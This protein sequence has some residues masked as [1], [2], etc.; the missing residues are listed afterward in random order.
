[1]TLLPKKSELIL[2]IQRSVDA[3]GSI[4]S[5]V[6]NKVLNVSIIES[7][8]NT[9]RSNHYHVKDYHFMYVLEGEIDYFFK[10]LHSDEVNYLKILK[11]ETIF[12]PN[13]EIHATYFAQKTKLIVSSGLPR[14]QKTYENDTRRVEFLNDK[15][16]DIF[17]K[18]YA[19]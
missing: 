15:N 1:M 17:F 19:M 2:N 13:K 3:R 9:I 10:S 11:G 14:D 6:D 8:K 7:E 12:T 4:L 16:L 5:I 18:N